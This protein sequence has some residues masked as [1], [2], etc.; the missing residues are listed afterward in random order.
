MV[1]LFLKQMWMVLSL[2]QYA[3]M[4]VWWQEPAQEIGTGGGPLHLAVFAATRETTAG[5]AARSSKDQGFSMPPRIL[6]SCSRATDFP[7][8][9]SVCFFSWRNMELQFLMLFTGI[10]ILSSMSLFP[11]LSSSLF[12]VADAL[13]TL[14]AVLNSQ[15]LTSMK[16]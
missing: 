8:K 16:Y 5:E 3:E 1:I 14:R 10:L 9:N 6:Y 7:L 13:W 12:V 2:K 15:L 4:A 11:R